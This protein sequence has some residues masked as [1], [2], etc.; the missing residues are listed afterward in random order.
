MEVGAEHEARL[1]REAASWA[2]AGV[3]PTPAA[4]DGG[5]ELPLPELDFASYLA[6]GEVGPLAEQLR[7][8]CEHGAGFFYAVNHGCGPELEALFGASA[9]FHALA[10][11]AKL[12]LAEESSGGLGVGYLAVGHRKLPRRA[13]GNRNASLIFKRGK[14]ALAG[15]GVRQLELADNPWPGE[16]LLPGFRAAV[17]AYASA[18]E[19][20]ARRLVR[21]YAAALG[22]DEGFFDA[23]A[24]APLWRLRLSHYPP[25]PAGARGYGIAPHV[26]T[27]FFTLLAQDAVPGL[28]LCRT[29]GTWRA[30]PAFDGGAAARPLLVNTGELLKMWSNDRFCSTRHYVL[31]TPGDG[32]A[33]QGRFSVPFFFNVDAAHEMTCLPT[34]TGPGNAP[35][36]APMSY[37][38]SQGVAQGE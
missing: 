29:D 13:D 20:F 27:S 26:D 1:Q 19:R 14:V 28:V 33:P 32:S 25:T 2:G 24:A 11:E 17:E 7:A 38:Q 16:G 18:A 6:G 8:A 23:P 10:E 34:C 5:A 9:R 35:R 21:V 3:A 30:V 37:L 31:P 4:A 36:Y 22:L 12:A 15:G